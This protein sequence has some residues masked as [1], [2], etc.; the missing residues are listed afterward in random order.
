MRMRFHLALYNK[1]RVKIVLLRTFSAVNVLA[2]T[3]E[4][5]AGYRDFIFVL[6]KT[7]NFMYSAI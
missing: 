1:I 4:I 2:L 3:T 5:G 7:S 6:Y